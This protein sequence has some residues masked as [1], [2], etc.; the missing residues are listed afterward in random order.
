MRYMH[1]EMDIAQFLVCEVLEKQLFVTL[2]KVK[3]LMN[4]LA[5]GFL[6]F[7]PTTQNSLLSNAVS[8]LPT[9]TGDIIFKKKINSK[10]PP[11]KEAKGGPNISCRIAAT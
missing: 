11:A 5:R 1:G 4:Q 10:S 3:E 9:A 8:N 2:F 7:G 6:G